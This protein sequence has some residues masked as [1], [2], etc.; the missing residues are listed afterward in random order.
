MSNGEVANAVPV[1][2]LSKRF[3]AGIPQRL[4][5]RKA[6]NRSMSAIV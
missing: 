4:E 6:V 5:F 1:S 2:A 3:P